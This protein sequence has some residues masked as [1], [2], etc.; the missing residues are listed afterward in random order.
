MLVGADDNKVRYFAQ[1]PSD[2]STV[3]DE[4]N[5]RVQA[6]AFSSK[7]DFVFVTGAMDK[8][9]KVWDVKTR[10]TVVNFDQSE[11]GITGLA[12]LPNGVQFVGSSLD[13]RLLWWGVNYDEK[14][15]TYGGYIYRGVGTHNA[16]VYRLGIAS[17][18]QRHNPGRADRN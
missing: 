7:P 3:L 10:K 13:G 16:G 5:G 6:V 1:L 12:F 11:G 17:N 8:I 4:H 18:G 2:D 14:K 15:Q 9:V